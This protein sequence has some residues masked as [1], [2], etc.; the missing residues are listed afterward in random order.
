MYGCVCVCVRVEGWLPAGKVASHTLHRL[1]PTDLAVVAGDD[2]TGETPMPVSSGVLYTLSY[3][4]AVVG[5]YGVLTMGGR[6]LTAPPKL[7][8]R[9]WL[10]L[11][12]LAIFLG[13]GY[14]SIFQFPFITL[15]MAI[16][17][18]GIVI[19]VLDSQVVIVV[20]MGGGSGWDVLRWL[21]RTRDVRLTHTT[22][23]LPLSLWWWLALSATAT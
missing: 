12:V 23:S 11:E 16:A 3:C 21:P 17:S 22:P 1:L 19:N 6:R 14:V 4:T 20:P 13:F 7:T 10:P 15:P 5:I 18:Y 9:F 2:V 8:D